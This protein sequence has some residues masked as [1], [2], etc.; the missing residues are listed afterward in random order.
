M[1]NLK[2]QKKVLFIVGFVILA[3]VL[4]LIIIRTQ[5]NKTN[6]TTANKLENLS[7][8]V[9]KAQVY[10]PSSNP[11]VSADDKIVGPKKSALTVFV[12]EDNASL[13]SAK[14]ADTLT[15][16]YSENQNKFT[17][18]I[19]PFI[20]KD[21]LISKDAALAIECA[22]D[23]NKWVEMRAFLFAKTKDANLNM[24]E[25]SVYAKQL[26][27]DETQFSAC[28]TNSQKSAKIEELSSTA[29]SYNVIGAPTVFVGDEMILGARPYA[30]YV[31]SNGDKIE[32]LNTII[33]KKLQ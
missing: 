17:I 24:S 6:L 31:D 3:L 28:L 14:L 26:S 27:L 12:Y 22:A 23:Q 33:L 5:N 4:V 30:D 15:K 19:R 20:P 32:G 8:D 2:N 25:L 9:A 29:A 10:T 18:V 1:K 7:A 21:S 16:I 13:Y 11:T